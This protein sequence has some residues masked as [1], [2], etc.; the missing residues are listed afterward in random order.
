MDPLR[1]RHLWLTRRELFKGVGLAALASLLGRDGIAAEPRLHF[2]PKAKR[3]VYLMQGGA[4]SHIDLF[5]HKPELYKRQG[6]ELPP[7]VMMRGEFFEIP[8]PFELSAAS[9]ARG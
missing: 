3:V 8:S 9:Q 1:E 2:A 4:P 5:D 6:Q 7:S